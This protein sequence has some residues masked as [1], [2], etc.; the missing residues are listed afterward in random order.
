MLLEDLQVILKV[1]EF[2]SITQAAA[3]LDMR[4]ATA[5]AA[6]KRVEASLGVELFVR[7]TRSLRL[8]SAGERYLPQCEEALQMLEK[9]KLNMKGDLDI[10][11]GE[12]RIAV[13]SDLGRNLA[14]GWIDEFMDQYPK[15]SLRAYLSDSNVDF[16]RDSIDMALR[17]GSPSDS[18]LYGFKICT[19]PKILCATPTYLAEHGTPTHPNDLN[20][21]NGLLYQVRDVIH[22]V[23]DFKHIDSYLESSESYKIKMRANR[24]S[25]DADLVRR[26]CVAG[27][28][29]AIKSGL[30]MANDLLTGNL[31]HVMPDYQAKPTEL[32]LVCPSKQ[33]ITPA[34]RI[35]RDSFR[36][37]S[38]AILQQ[39]V[40]RGILDSR[41]VD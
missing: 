39:L 4:V 32:W 18:N 9:A 16:Y 11:D 20:A 26:W 17:Y 38:K 29:L 15:V 21:H 23:W 14:M 5:S 36:A 40:E 12:L 37:K 28:G 6:V 1:A 3:N 34:V 2:R 8:S 35:L 31:V 19:I 7:T 27:K 33:S 22:D 10:I 25:N 13:S 24:S 30:D 41:L